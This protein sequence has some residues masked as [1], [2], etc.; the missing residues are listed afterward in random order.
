MNTPTRM[1]E[2][3]LLQCFQYAIEQLTCK[4]VWEFIELVLKTAKSKKEFKALVKV[5][6]G[7]PIVEKCLKEASQCCPAKYPTITTVVQTTTTVT[8]TQQ[9]TGGK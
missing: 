2:V 3:L 7:L 1:I 8:T 5:F 9:I 6:K 4:D